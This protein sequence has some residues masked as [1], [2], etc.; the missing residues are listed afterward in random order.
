M[1]ALGQKQKSVWT[2]E[3]SQSFPGPGAGAF[4]HAPTLSSGQ[5]QTRHLLLEE[6]AGFKT[7][8]EGFTGPK[9]RL[10]SAFKALKNLT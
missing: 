6:M 4:H 3:W 7:P 10:N 5:R 2:A 8:L 9:K 1:S